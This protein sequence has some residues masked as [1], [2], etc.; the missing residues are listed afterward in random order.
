[1]AVTTVGD[2]SYIGVLGPFKMEVIFIS[3]ASNGDT[4]VSKLQNPSFAVCLPTEDLQG[5][6]HPSAGLS[7]KT[8]TINDPPTTGNGDVVVIVFGDSIKSIT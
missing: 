1:M 6:A 5:D 4:V 3:T 2:I 8:V 7:G